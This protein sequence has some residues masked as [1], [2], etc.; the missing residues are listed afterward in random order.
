MKESAATQATPGHKMNIKEKR[1]LSGQAD[2]C[3]DQFYV[4]LRFFHPKIHRPT[5]I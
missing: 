3:L 4:T 5:S 2:S 1:G